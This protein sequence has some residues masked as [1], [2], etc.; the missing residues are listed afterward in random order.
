MI[1]IKKAIMLL[2]QKFSGRTPVGYWRFDNA[3][4]IKTKPIGVLKNLTAPALFVVT[5]DKKVYGTTPMEYDL[6]IDK[7]IKL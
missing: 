7:M 6:D 1:S 4:V 3:Y 2:K 5:D